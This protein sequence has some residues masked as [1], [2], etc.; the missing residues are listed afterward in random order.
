MKNSVFLGVLCGL[1]LALACDDD[2]DAEE[3]RDAT[4][5]TENGSGGA[6][7]ATKGGA[8][9]GGSSDTGHGGTSGDGNVSCEPP[10]PPDLDLG[11]SGSGGSGAA[12]AALAIVGAY[13]DDFMGQH[14][15]TNSEWTSGKSVFHIARFSNLEKWVIAQN[16]EANMYSPC[17]WSRFD[18]AHADDKLYYCQTVYDGASQAFALRAPPADSADVSAGCGGF[19][20]TELIL[21]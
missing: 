19:S 17:L 21:Q 4:G 2:D 3:A 6:S 5:G 8:E 9:A 15:I 20:W 16:D 10:A 7:I 13:A 18:W 12:G 1:C 14:V 11:A